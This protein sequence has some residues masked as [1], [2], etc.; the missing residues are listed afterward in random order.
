MVLKVDHELVSTVVNDSVQHLQPSIAQDEIDGNR[1][2]KSDSDTD[3]PTITVTVG[4]PE[5][6]Y[7]G[8]AHRGGTVCVFR[9]NTC[10]TDKG[11]SS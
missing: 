6:H 8:Q 1:R 4:S 5:A 9:D 11:I 10:H 2:S 3:I 7:N